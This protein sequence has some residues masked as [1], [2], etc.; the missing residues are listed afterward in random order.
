[1]KTKI[2]KNA[3]KCKKC[4]DVIES[5]FR[6]D[7]VSCK[8]GAIFVDGGKDYLRRGGDLDDIIDLSEWESEGENSVSTFD[9]N[10]LVI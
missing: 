8:C 3:A 1:M 2:I 6:H 10:N 7:F 5:T 9:P 4:K